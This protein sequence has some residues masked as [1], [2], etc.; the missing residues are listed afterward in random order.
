M[1]G[2]YTYPWVYLNGVEQAPLKNNGYLAF[3]IQPG[4]HELVVKGKSADQWD[5]AD[6]KISLIASPNQEYFVKINIGSRVGFLGGE[7]AESETTPSLQ[8]SI[9]KVILGAGLEP[10][11]NEI[12]RQEISDLN[13]SK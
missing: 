7:L 4:K 2:D 10:V 6:Q 3:E 9:W 11:E 1:R 5:F 12:G 8:G 13:L